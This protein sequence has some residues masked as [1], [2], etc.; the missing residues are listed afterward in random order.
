MSKKRVMVTGGGGFIGM[1]VIEE[2]WKRDCEVVYFDVIEPKLKGIKR[3]NRG[4]ILDQYD[5]A[6]AVRGCDYAV[7][8][9][10]V[11]GVQRTDNNRLE[12]LYINIQ[13]TLNVIEA[14]V[15]EGVK[16]VVFS[17]SSEV[18]GDQ[19]TLPLTEN[20]PLNPKSV[21][22]VSKITG[23]QYLQ[24]YSDMYGIQY[25]I[26][27]FFN[28][29]GEY[30]RE[31]FV[32][33]RFVQRVVNNEAPIIYG[34]GEQVRSF[35]YV[36]DAA[37]GLVD[38]LLTETNGEVFNI[39]NDREPISMKDLANKVIELSGK[40]LIPEFVSYE[41]SDRESSREISKRI[42]CIKKAKSLLG[43][44]PTFSLEQGLK[45]MLTFY[46]NNWKKS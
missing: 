15:K 20:N 13:G 18:Y 5:L 37:R 4:T 44:E 14:C 46:E 3:V 11:L 6:S 30:Q 27:R 40:S 12:T 39:G 9:A 26:V 17:S 34:D 2:L 24:A 38:A 28:V 21:Y 19:D 43:Y 7:H 16:K 8:L 22:A 25:N 23:E 33:P 32:L 41:Q 35:C 29:Y 42:P 10:A 36:E 31:E 1:K 45:R